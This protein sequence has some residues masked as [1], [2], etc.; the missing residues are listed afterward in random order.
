MGAQGALERTAPPAR[1][2]PSEALALM[3]AQTRQA[4]QQALEQQ[5]AGGASGPQAA[6][7]PADSRGGASPA[8]ERAADDMGGGQGLRRDSIETEEGLVT[9]M[10]RLASSAVAAELPEGSAEEEDLEM[11]LGPMPPTR[12]RSLAPALAAAAVAQ[13]QAHDRG[14]EPQSTAAAAPAV[15]QAEQG[16]DPLGAT[17][18]VGTRS[19]SASPAKPPDKPSPVAHAGLAAGPRPAD[20]AG[21]AAS[22]ASARPEGGRGMRGLPQRELMRETSELAY[23]A[24]DGRAAPCAGSGPRQM[25]SSC[26]LPRR[27]RLRPWTRVLLRWQITGQHSWKGL[28]ACWHRPRLQQMLRMLIYRLVSLVACKGRA[29]TMQV[30]RL[31]L[32][33]LRHQ[34]SLHMLRTYSWIQQRCLQLQLP[35]VADCRVTS[36]SRFG[37]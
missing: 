34:V 36:M 10:E 15:Q 23:V 26:S 32:R 17:T 21:P 8:A 27:R 33:R 5:P 7:R 19:A 14:P 31:L 28:L 6:G 4:Q 1:R 13:P 11:L 9:Q 25:P 12:S 24:R 30:K 3:M 20:N 22:P 29:Q 2:P 35:R 37:Y 18:N 16:F